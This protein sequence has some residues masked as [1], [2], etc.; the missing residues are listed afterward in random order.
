M[1]SQ[2]HYEFNLGFLLGSIP[3]AR[4]FLLYSFLYHLISS[5]TYLSLHFVIQTSAETPVICPQELQFVST[6][7]ESSHPFPST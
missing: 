4:W 2:T 1:P 3:Q 6:G 7:H 5:L